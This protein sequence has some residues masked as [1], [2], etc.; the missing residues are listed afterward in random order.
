MPVEQHTAG[1]VHVFLHTCSTDTGI[2]VELGVGSALAWSVI[3]EL[4]TTKDKIVALI[5][6]SPSAHPT[7]PT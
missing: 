7:E 3:V 5:R 6:A 4:L 2:A 1:K